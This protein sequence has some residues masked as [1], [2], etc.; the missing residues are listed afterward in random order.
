MKKKTIEELIKKANAIHRNKYKYDHYVLV[1]TH[2]PSCITCPIHGDFLQSFDAHIHQKSGCPEC[3]KIKRNKKNT[4]FNYDMLSENDVKYSFN[5]DYLN[6]EYNGYDAKSTVTCPIHGEF[7]TSWHKLKYGH[8]CPMCGNKKNYSELR[9]KSILEKEFNKV[10][11]QK[12]F[13]WLGRQSLDFYLPQYNVAIEYQGRQHF[14]EYSL[15]NHDETLKSDLTKLENCKAHN[16]PIYYITF[17]G[18]YIPIDFSYYKL[19]TDIN[20]LIKNI[21][22]GKRK[23]KIK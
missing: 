10:E 4:K 2:T 3:A 15:F 12:R 6:F 23:T 14:C 5:Y 1:N 13:D 11:Y 19:Y 9:L 21:K 17:E 7:I 18:K 22:Y 8:G 16:I 20:N